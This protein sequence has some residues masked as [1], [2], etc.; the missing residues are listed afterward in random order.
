[1]G[2]QLA[3]VEGPHPAV[4]QNQ[5]DWCT[6]QAGVASA[7][8][9]VLAA[10]L[11]VLRAVAMSAPGAGAGCAVGAAAAARNHPAQSANAQPN[12]R[13]IGHSRTGTQT[14][15]QPRQVVLWLA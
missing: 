15:V 10:A 3:A 7:D 13:R 2:Q 9:A 1:M 11:Y 6:W 5:L 4:R 8:A 14:H 12:G